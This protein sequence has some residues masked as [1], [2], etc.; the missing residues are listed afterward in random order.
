MRS[1][2]RL[3]RQKENGAR[4]FEIARLRHGDDRSQAKDWIA[5]HN[6]RRSLWLY[7]TFVILYLGQRHLLGLPYA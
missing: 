5:F 4:G 6:V 2:L 1:Q 7:E 3:Q